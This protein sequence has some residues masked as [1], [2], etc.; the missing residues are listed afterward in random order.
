VLNAQS[1]IV[2][3]TIRSTKKKS[4]HAGLAQENGFWLSILALFAV[5]GKRRRKDVHFQKR[6]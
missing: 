5:A 3:S 6:V 1:A 2:H 4:K